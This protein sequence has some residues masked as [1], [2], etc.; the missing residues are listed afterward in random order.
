MAPAGRPRATALCSVPIEAVVRSRDYC[1]R[2]FQVFLD[3]RGRG[4]PRPLAIVPVIWQ[5]CKIPAPADS[6]QW[7]DKDVAD[8]FRDW[9][10]NR[11]Q[12]WGVPIL[13]APESRRDDFLDFNRSHCA[14]FSTTIKS[15]ILSSL[16]GIIG[17]LNISSAWREHQATKLSQRASHSVG[18]RLSDHECRAEWQR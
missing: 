4:M 5:T 1:G 16:L 18:R 3:R 13:E 14:G 9:I 12:K 10:T 15:F 8:Q 11:S 17:H 6:V 2:E 7:Y